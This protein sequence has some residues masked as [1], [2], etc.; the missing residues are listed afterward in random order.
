MNGMLRLITLSH[1]FY[2][3]CVDVIEQHQ[4]RS[5]DMMGEKGL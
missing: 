4:L 3:M 5:Y 2:L 1:S